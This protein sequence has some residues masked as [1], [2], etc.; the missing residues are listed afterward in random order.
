MDTQPQENQ[1]RSR[2]SAWTL[3]DWANSA[4]VTVTASTFFPPYFIAIAAPAF[5]VMGT[6]GAEDAARNTASNVF[7][8]ATSLALFI[9]AVLSP[10]IGTLADIQGRRKRYLLVATAT[11]GVLASLMF[12][13]TTGLWLPGLIVFGLT[14]ISLHVALGLYDSLLPHTARPEDMDR[15]SSQG[16]ALGYVGGGLLLLMNTVIFLF[17]ENLGIESDL[18]VRIA[19]L[20]VGVWWI[21]FSIPLFLRVPEP[22]ATPLAESRG[23]PI[24]DTVQR[25]RD[26]LRDIR[27]YKELFK[28]LVAFW[29]YMEGIGAIILLATA[30]GA[31]LGLDTAILIGTLLM[32]QFVAF[33]YALIFGKITNPQSKWRS[34]FVSMLL[35]TAV[36]LPLIGAYSNVTQSVD[37][38]QGFILIAVSQ[39]VGAVFSVFIGR[40]LLAG[41]T[42]RLSTKQ[43][44]MLGLLIYTIIPIWGFFVRTQAEFFMIGWMV[45]TVQGGTQAL[46]RSIFASLSPRAKSGEFFGLYGLSEKFAGIMGPLLYGIVG[47]LSGSPRA[48]VVSIS[49]FFVIGILLLAR[50]REKEGAAAAAQEDAQ[51]ALAHGAD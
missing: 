49:V 46:S 4:Y 22:P 45:G 27:R 17:A 8:L 13:I 10:F 36:T 42:E 23:N 37:V 11:G 16:Y 32:T 47:T 48:S 24:R 6:A 40:R 25:I 44:V 12:T 2:L 15:T 14:Q 41:F 50:V 43:V 39:A 5:L 3:Y 38:A 26:T 51:I 9:A 34:A 29:F 20:S 21:I 1:Y 35:W 19:F 7:A 30:Y 31:A 28:M 18:A 33:P